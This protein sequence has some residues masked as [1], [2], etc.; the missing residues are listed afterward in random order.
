MACYSPLI[1]LNQNAVGP[2]SLSKVP[3]FTNSKCHIITSKEIEDL[4]TEPHGSPDRQHK[5]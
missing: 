1:L 5:P 2:C 4:I 3:S